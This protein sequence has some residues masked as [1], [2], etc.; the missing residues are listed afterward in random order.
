MKLRVESMDQ[1][2]HQGGYVSDGDRQATSG[3]L[4]SKTVQ[5]D[6]KTNK[7]LMKP[8]IIPFN[9]DLKISHLAFSIYCR[10]NLK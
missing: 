10:S 9:K 6:K 4:K 7:P 1:L 2:G 3:T 5:K 8:L